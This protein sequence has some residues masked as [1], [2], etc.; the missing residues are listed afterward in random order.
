[1]W[2]FSLAFGDDTAKT[3][4]WIQVNAPYCWLPL[5]FCTQ[6]HVVCCFGRFICYKCFFSEK[7]DDICLDKFEWEID[8]HHSNIE[9][10]VLVSK[11]LYIGIMMSHRRR[12]TAV[13]YWYI[14]SKQKVKGKTHNLQMWK[15]GL[16]SYTFM[17]AIDMDVLI[18][19][20]LLHLPAIF[21]WMHSQ[22]HHLF[23]SFRIVF[24]LQNIIKDIIRSSIMHSYPQIVLKVM[25][26]NGKSGNNYVDNFS[27]L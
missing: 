8:I 13:W 11:C 15:K 6:Y 22:Q 27:R 4:F 12:V 26:F 3:A 9:K 21:T 24:L 23:S 1:M 19:L 25:I 5:V 7:V 14:K 2:V 16:H 18:C 20:C 17:N 10:C